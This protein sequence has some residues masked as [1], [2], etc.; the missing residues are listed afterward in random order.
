[1]YIWRHHGKEDTLVHPIML[2]SGLLLAQLSLG[3]GAYLVEYTPMAMMATS[4]LRVSLTTIHL[5]VGSLLLATSVVLTLRTYRL[6]TTSTPMITRTLL[7]E[8]VSL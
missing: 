2:L 8:Q 4:S 1:M 6:G 7:S 3:L 5:A